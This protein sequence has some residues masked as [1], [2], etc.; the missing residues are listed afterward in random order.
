MGK[1]EEDAQQSGPFLN[2]FFLP[3][4]D[5]IPYSK[6]LSVSLPFFFFYYYFFLQPFPSLL[7]LPSFHF[8]LT[9]NQT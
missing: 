7:I 9:Y 3:K 8:I 1:L 2:P 6:S 5:N 4:S